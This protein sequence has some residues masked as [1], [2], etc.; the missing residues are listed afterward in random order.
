[1]VRKPTEEVQLKLRFEER[2]RRLL[3]RAAEDNNRSM[4]AEIVHR[5]EVSF[6]RADQEKSIDTIVQQTALATAAATAMT[7]RM[8]IIKFLQGE[9]QPANPPNP[10]QKDKAP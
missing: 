7:T 4:N 2:L 6:K 8:E 10:E 3:E 5:L 1:M 9:T